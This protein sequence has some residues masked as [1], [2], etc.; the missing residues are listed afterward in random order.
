[1]QIRTK[2]TLQFIIVVILIIVFSFGSIYYSSS[3][4]RKHEFYTRLES[5]A[6]INYDLFSNYRM[7]DPAMLIL[8]DRSQKEKLPGECIL[9]FNA[10]DKIVY[11]S[12]D[13]INRLITPAM[14]QKLKSTNRIEV[15]SGPYEIL[16][17]RITENNTVNFVFAMAKDLYGYSKLN[18]L[19]A[20]MLLLLILIISIVAIAGW[21]Y[22]GRALAP[23]SNV[24][25]EVNNISIESLHRRLPVSENKDE[26]GRLVLTFNS[27]LEQI[28][29][30]VKLQRL[31]VSGASHEL[32]NP[33]TSI[34]TQLQVGL[35]NARTADE[36][37]LLLSSVKEDIS[38]L[39]R[40]TL[41]LI[42]YARLN[43]KDEIQF[44]KIRI[45]DVILQC[46]DLFLADNNGCKVSIHFS[47]MPA[48]ES[49]LLI[50]GNEA[51]LKVA[52]NNLIDNAC[53]FS[54]NKS[55]AITFS[56]HKNEFELSFADK[57][58]GM[59]KEEIQFIFEP[60]YR[61]N[62]TAEVKGHGLGLALTKKIIELHKGY[63]TVDSAPGAGSVFVIKLPVLK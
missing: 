27:M 52:F 60:F 57:G 32:K 34:T 33:L 62:S 13:S 40:T 42:E 1:M 21:N 2:L 51:F 45:D 50:N 6:K 37:R 11:S 12:Q 8:F 16:G 61:S 17:M 15:S 59:S 20:T 14:R 38:R 49:L 41:D 3:N 48:D 44:Q 9:I 26:I 5:K 19:R 30:S 28:E 10:Q 18:N 23:L 22:A 4:Y 7:A 46:R 43:Y 35:M 47:H 56:A 24:I 54:T 63:I 36:Y 29:K 53:K 58:L 25:D 31:F 55:C 39:N